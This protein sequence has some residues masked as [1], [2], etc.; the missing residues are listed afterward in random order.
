MQGGWKMRAVWAVSWVKLRPD[1]LMASRSF[2]VVTGATST[3]DPV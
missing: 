2:Q 3:Q 1:G